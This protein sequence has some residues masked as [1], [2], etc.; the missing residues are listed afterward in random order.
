[1]SPERALTPSEWERFKRL[2]LVHLDS[3]YNLAR[4]L[5]RDADDA[6][7]AVQEACVRA[8]RHFGG[9]RG[10]SGRA[11]LLTIT[12]NTCWNVLEKRRASLAA[13]EF[14]EMLHTP[15]PERPEPEAD[16]ERAM[17]AD[18]LRRSLDALPLVFREAIVLRELEGLSY[19]EIAEVTAVPAGTV[20]S[21]LARARA[22]LTQM[23][24][25]VPR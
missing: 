12:R 9:F 8:L 23:L 21:R 4:H 14:D 24:H 16:L 1:V 13:T 7:D 20:M 19:R 5:V 25:G 3:A 2:V 18:V 10:E 6:E 22:H 15:E 17:A 11:W